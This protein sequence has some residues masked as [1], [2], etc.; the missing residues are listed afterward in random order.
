[1]PHYVLACPDMNQVH[2]VA[3]RA[4]W[5]RAH[6]GVVVPNRRDYNYVQR[7]AFAAQYGCAWEEPPIH[8]G[9]PRRAWFKTRALPYEPTLSEKIEA[10]AKRALDDYYGPP[11][12]PIPFPGMP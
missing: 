1:M 8:P 7:Q 5:S 12:S 11:R 10:H 3:E 9:A 2:N 4:A 6:G